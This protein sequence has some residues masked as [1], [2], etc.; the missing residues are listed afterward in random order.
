MPGQK[1]EEPGSSLVM[2]KCVSARYAGS[3]DASHT[4]REYR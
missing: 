1:K 2:H 4:G 3:A